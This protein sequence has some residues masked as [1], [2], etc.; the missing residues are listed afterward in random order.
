MKNL[1]FK[2][3]WNSFLLSLTVLFWL[4]RDFKS[5]SLLFIVI[6]LVALIS[7]G[8]DTVQFYKAMKENQ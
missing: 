7:T 2:G 4:V 5:N 8:Y 1:A 6:G 3:F